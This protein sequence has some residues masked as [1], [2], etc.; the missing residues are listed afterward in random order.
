MLI[1]HEL[2]TRSFIAQYTAK[3]IPLVTL[4]CLS[5]NTWSSEWH[6][7]LMSPQRTGCQLIYSPAS[8]LLERALNDDQRSSSFELTLNQNSRNFKVYLKAI[9]I[10]Q[11]AHPPS[12]PSLLVAEDYTWT[13]VLAGKNLF[14]PLSAESLDGTSHRAH[15][16]GID[17]IYELP[18]QGQR[19]VCHFGS[20]SLTCCT[21]W[22]DKS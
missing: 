6:R 5:F 15:H 12:V 19:A 16:H 9:I 10:G 7:M 13:F 18:A 4:A 14:F 21:L 17:F 22:S 1:D 2:T 8:V 3:N 20:E 11:H